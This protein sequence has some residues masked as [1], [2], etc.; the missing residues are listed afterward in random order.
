MYNANISNNYYKKRRLDVG[1]VGNVQVSYQQWFNHDDGILVVHTLSFLDVKSLLQKERVNKTWRKLCRKTYKG[2]CGPDGPTPFQSNQELRDTIC[3]YCR[4]R[5]ASAM[6][7]VA[8]TY[9]YPID[10]WDVSQIENMNGVFDCT[11]E[12][13]NMSTFNEYIGS[14]DVSNVTD[15]SYMFH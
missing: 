13:K 1:M 4:C 14:W 6:E 12:F 5:A 11:S 9:G 7:G 10:T 3:T 15:M 8:V 2:K